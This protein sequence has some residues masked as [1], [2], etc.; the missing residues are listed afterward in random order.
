MEVS[1]DVEISTSGTDEGDDLIVVLTI[2]DSFL[3][4]TGGGKL[5]PRIEAQETSTADLEREMVSLP[6]IQT[7]PGILFPHDRACTGSRLRTVFAQSSTRNVLLNM[8]SCCFG[9]SRR[10]SSNYQ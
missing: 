4:A 10:K 8:K 7:L 3:L 1:D 5:P 6:P 2:L 9:R